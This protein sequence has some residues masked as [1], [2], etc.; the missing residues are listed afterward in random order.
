MLISHRCICGLIPNLIKKSWTVSTATTVPCQSEQY[1]G[2][3]RGVLVLPDCF[4]FPYFPYMGIIH[5]HFDV[6]KKT[7]EVWNCQVN[8]KNR[9]MYSIL[10]CTNLQKLQS[11]S[12]FLRY[13]N[14]A[15]V[16]ITSDIKISLFDTSFPGKTLPRFDKKVQK[17]QT[18][19]AF[20]VMTDRNSWWSKNGK[21]WS[22]IF[23]Y[24]GYHWC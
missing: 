15:K 21:E 2:I 1:W 18:V 8:Q 11:G 24:F 14:C 6:R 9:S 5:S 16:D 3:L 12:K 22:A 4:S 10:G 7:S 20:V 19:S 17:Q 23:S 13:G